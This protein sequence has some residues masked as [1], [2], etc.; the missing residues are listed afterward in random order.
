MTLLMWWIPLLVMQNQTGQAE[1]AQTAMEASL[2]KQRLS[3]QQQVKATGATRKMAK[4]H[5]AD[6]VFTPTFPCNPLE[7]PDLD[8]MI[9]EAAHAQQV[10][11]AVVREVARQESSFYPCAVSPKGAAGLMQLMPETQAQF[12]VRDPLDPQESLV[13]GTRLL[14]KLLE[15]YHGNLPLA[16]GAYN[17]GVSRI[18]Q[19]FTIPAIPETQQ[20]VQDILSRL[21]P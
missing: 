19:S 4:W 21:R 18:D 6:A 5:P 15:R 16:L 7:K 12:Q 14:K 3:V 8:K 9:D 20:Y 13:A 17:A 1:R 2:E 11:P 10:D